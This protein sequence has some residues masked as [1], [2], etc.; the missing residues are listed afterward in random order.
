[1]AAPLNLQNG[2]AS[3]NCLK[4]QPH[5]CQS[6]LGVTDEIE[7]SSRLYLGEKMATTGLACRV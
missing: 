7:A 1:M 4:Q 3:L 5:I 2:T 6:C